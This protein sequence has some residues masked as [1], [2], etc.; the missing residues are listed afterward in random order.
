MRLY[1]IA[2]L[3]LSFG[4]D[5]PMDIFH[6]WENHAVRIEE[7]WRRLVRPEDTVMIPGDVSW[8]VTMEQAKADF[9]FIHRL[10][11]K[12]II[13]RGNHDYW[14]TTKTKV[15]KALAGWGFDSISILFN[16]CYEFGGYCLCA[17]RGWVNESG[18]PEDKKVLNREAGRLRLSLEAGV[19]TGKEII[20]FLHYPPIYGGSECYEI[21]DV[22]HE[23]G[24]KT[25]YYGHL[26]GISRRYAIGGVRDGIYYELI[27]SDHLAFAPKLLLDSACGKI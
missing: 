9:A 7:N 2:D 27:S 18:E 26:H 13:S 22:L 6:G 10:P 19:K 21:L 25:C 15:E 11:G 23:Y 20:A 17:T 16:N 5:K 1:G 14:F 24:V 3:H 8:A 4:T 12:K